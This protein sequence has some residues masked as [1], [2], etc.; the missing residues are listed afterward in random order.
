[1]LLVR[2]PDRYPAERAYAL[3]V[4]LKDFLGLTWAGLPEQR[5][6]VEITLA[7]DDRGR[8]VLLPDVLFETPPADWLTARS[9]PRLPLRRWRLDGHRTPSPGVADGMP[10]L[11]ERRVSHMD[12]LSETAGGITL[13]LDVFGG[14]FFQ[15]TRYEE[16][17]QAERDAHLRFAS[18]KSL[19]H[20]EGFLTRPLANEYVELLWW[21]LSRA[22]P[23][24]RRAHR[25]F[26]E[27]PS[28]DVDSPLMSTKW[29]RQI[30]KAAGGDLLRRRDP[31]LAFNT[32]R[33]LAARLLSNSDMDP[34]NTF[35][36]IMEDS[37]RAGLRSSF[38]FIAGKSEPALD[39]RYSLADPWIEALMKRIHERGHEIG[40]HPSYRTFRDVALLKREQE[41]LLSV[42]DRLGITQAEWG[43]RQHFLRW[44][45]PTTWRAWEQAG[46]AYDSS[47]G[48]SDRG[49]F[50]CGIC[51]EYSVFDL[52]A[53]E[54]LELRER[55]LV[56]MDMA[57]LD[58][59]ESTTATGAATIE[60]LRRTC[61]RF[62]GDFT[63]LWHNSRLVSRKDL[64]VYRA[65]TARRRF[66]AK[67]DT[68]PSSVRGEH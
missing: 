64:Q 66:E 59:P 68:Q 18:Q 4:V 5:D 48:F 30:V 32:A 8:G 57:A 33:G 55:P 37:E 21:A 26:R 53:R 17:V 27:L 20:R 58:T 15:L 28:H 11:Y 25:T 12:L 52:L 24:L 42:C 38:Y 50:R 7:E 34:Y 16:I 2:H 41:R 54:R 43:G 51:Y 13:S 6:D 22:F 40:L 63:L 46:L 60:E 35:E 3:D 44:E 10:I 61:R 19:A 49:G 67:I 62:N 29:T 65:V 9:L 45:N 56:I 23:R 47:L 14:V 39:G 1:M 31:T 36:R